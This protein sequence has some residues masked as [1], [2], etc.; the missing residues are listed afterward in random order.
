MFSSTKEH[1]IP[2]QGVGDENTI[3]KPISRI[4]EAQPLVFSFGDCQISPTQHNRVYIR[5][6]GLAI[7]CG[8]RFDVHSSQNWTVHPPSSRPTS[9]L[10]SCFA[11]NHRTTGRGRNSR[12]SK[13]TISEP[14]GTFGSR[15]LFHG[16][17]M[18]IEKTKGVMHTV[19][20]SS[21]LSAS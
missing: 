2:L 7:G 14:L 4:H 20:T 16:M 19:Q 1:S 6:M 12:L 18:G 10:T 15:L 21:S 9:C 13:V 5:G 11:I 17:G 3:P 8:R